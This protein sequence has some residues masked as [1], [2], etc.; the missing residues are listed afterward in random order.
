MSSWTRRRAA[1]AWPIPNLIEGRQRAG[2]KDDAA[3]A[4]AEYGARDGKAEALNEAA[5]WATGEILVFTDARQMVE[6]NAVSELTACFADPEVGGVSG[7]L[8]LEG[9]SDSRS[10]AVGT[11]WKIEKLVRKLES[12]SGSVIGATGALYAMRRS[13]Y[14]EIPSATILDDVIIPMNIIRQGNRVIF[15]LARMAGAIR[16]N[17]TRQAPRA[18]KVSAELR[19]SADCPHRR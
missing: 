17:T 12:E 16:R 4:V 8:M 15:Q 11:Y 14:K 13:L 3:T 10:N 18:R 2:L 19:H 7:E 6:S 1:S 9:D 5:K